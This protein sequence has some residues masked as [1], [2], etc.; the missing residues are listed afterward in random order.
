VEDA[1][2]RV[3]L[4]DNAVRNPK[5]QV[6]VTPMV[7]APVAENVRAASLEPEPLRPCGGK[8]MHSKSRTLSF[9]RFWWETCPSEPAQMINLDKLIM[10]ES[11]R[12]AG[13]QHQDHRDFCWSVGLSNACRWG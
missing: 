13:R 1:S 3:Q 11:N 10:I 9:P 5:I 2:G 8:R 12:L 6:D 4:V 7:C